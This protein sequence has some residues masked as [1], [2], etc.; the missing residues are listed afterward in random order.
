[1]NDI[2]IYNIND[3]KLKHLFENLPQCFCGYEL[4][5]IRKLLKKKDQKRSLVGKIAT[6]KILSEF[7]KIKEDSFI[8]GRDEFDRPFLKAPKFKKIDFNISHSED[9]VLVAFHSEVKIGVDIEKIRPIDMK[10]M[11][12]VFTDEEIGYVES[13]KNLS[14]ERFYELWSLKESFVKAVGE[15]LS[16]PLKNFHFEFED[17]KII[18]KIN[19]KESIWNFKI[20]DLENYKIAVCSK[21]GNFPKKINE[22]KLFL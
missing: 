17:E 5:K 14:L 13:D 22:S 11:E 6:A 2:R 7:L 10:I 15:G 1:M 3:Y 8:F 9:Y 18:H 16:Y 20:Y 4:S 19:K 21:K 12:N